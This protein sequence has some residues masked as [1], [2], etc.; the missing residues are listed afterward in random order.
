MVGAANLASDKSGKLIKKLHFD[1]FWKVNYLS[2]VKA[3]MLR[4]H[5]ISSLEDQRNVDWTAAYSPAL[6]L[7]ICTS[8]HVNIP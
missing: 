8:V 2:N 6:K 4:L 1:F 5:D 7:H 3:P